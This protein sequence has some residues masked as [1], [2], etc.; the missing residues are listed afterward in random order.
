MAVTVSRSTVVAFGWISQYCLL[1][2]WE[3][4]LV[5]VVVIPVCI[6]AISYL[7]IQLQERTEYVAAPPL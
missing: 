7:E 5:G 2:A 1:H 6:C 3:D 4:L